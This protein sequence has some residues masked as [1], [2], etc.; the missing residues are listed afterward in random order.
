MNYDPEDH[1]QIIYMPIIEK[2]EN[3]V[4]KKEVVEREKI[5][6]MF[7]YE[8]VE[9]DVEVKEIKFVDVIKPVEQI[10]YKEI[11]V[12]EVEIIEIPVTKLRPVRVRKKVVVEQVIEVP[13]PIVE[14]V[15][16]FLVETSVIT[17][18]FI[19]SRL[20]SV[21]SQ[22]LN[23]TLSESAHRVIDVIVNEYIP[24]PVDHEVFLPVPVGRGSSDR[25]SRTLRC[26]SISSFHNPVNIPPSQWNSL[27]VDANPMLDNSEIEN[28]LI[29]QKGCC[30]MI[31]GNRDKIVEPQFYNMNVKEISSDHKP[32]I[33]ERT[34]PK[35]KKSSLCHTSGG[36]RPEHRASNLNIPIF[37]PL[38]VLKSSRCVVIPDNDSEVKTPAHATPNFHHS[39]LVF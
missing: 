21:I 20:P 18:R 39:H 11:L 29:Y 5:V 25:M 22:V 24:R 8:Y 38:R 17:P 36:I 26:T 28:V 14:M 13:G 4:E 6:P 3:Y 30:P 10:I 35:S 27:L 33:K 23:I 19:P 34:E 32:I 37:A 7:E 9:R 2:V 1:D 16:P 15:V 12:P 31:D